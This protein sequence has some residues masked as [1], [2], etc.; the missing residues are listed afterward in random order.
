MLLYIGR[1][2][3]RHLIVTHKVILKKRKEKCPEIFDMGIQKNLHA[4]NT[5][6]VSLFYVQERRKDTGSVIIGREKRKQ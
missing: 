5:S 6:P 4:F 2:I 1:Y 3:T